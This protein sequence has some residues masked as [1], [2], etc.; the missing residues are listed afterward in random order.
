ME[1]LSRTFGGARCVWVRSRA[2][3]GV[4]LCKQAIVYLKG[5]INASGKRPTFSLNH[6]WGKWVVHILTEAE[7][8]FALGLYDMCG[9]VREFCWERYAWN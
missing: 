6:R 5:R 9:N 7:W 1:R 3:E 4:D 8:E 2:G